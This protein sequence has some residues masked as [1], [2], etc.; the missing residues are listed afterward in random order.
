MLAARCAASHIC[1][2]LAGGAF[3]CEPA[4]SFNGPHVPRNALA[5][6]SQSRDSEAGEGILEDR[7]ACKIEIEN[8]SLGRLNDSMEALEAFDYG[9]VCWWCS[10]PADS[11]EHKYK[12]SDVVAEFGRPPYHDGS[13]LVR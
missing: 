3:R 1:L 11:A 6:L 7:A 8:C 12:R 10:N 5:S 9:G 4:Q 2:V 13:S